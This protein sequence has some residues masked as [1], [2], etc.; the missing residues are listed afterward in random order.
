MGLRRAY[1]APTNTDSNI[2]LLSFRSHNTLRLYYRLSLH[3]LLK[4]RLVNCA[5]NTNS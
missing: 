1:L 4:H 3:A 5:G 2:F